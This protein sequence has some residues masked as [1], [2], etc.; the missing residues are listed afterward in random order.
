MGHGAVSGE[1]STVGFL[2]VGIVSMTPLENKQAWGFEE[3]INYI[4]IRLRKV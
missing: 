2:I 3:P 1:Q 4:H